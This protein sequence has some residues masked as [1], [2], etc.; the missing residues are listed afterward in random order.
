MRGPIKLIDYELSRP[1]PTHRGLN[2]YVAIQGLVRLHGAPIGYVSVP[3]Q[4]SECPAEAVR[5]AILKEHFYAIAKEQLR[6]TMTVAPRAGH[7]RIDNLFAGFPDDHLDAG[8]NMP[9][10]TVAVCTRDRT[11]HLPLCLDALCRLDYPH[12]DLL[13]V[14]NAPSTEKTEQLVKRSYPNVRYVLEE[15]PGLDWARNCAITKAEGDIIAYTDDDVVVDKYWVQELARVFA[16]D[17]TVMAVTGLVIPYELETEAQI[18]FEQYGG[19]GRGFI[20]KWYQTDDGTKGKAM[21]FGGTGQF[22]TGANMAY[23]R[24]LFEEIGYFDPAL[25]VGTATNGGGD[26]EMFFRVI[27]HGY[28]LVYEPRAIVRHRHRRDYAALKTQIANNGVGLYSYFVCSAGAYP[29]ERIAFL[30]FGLWWMWY[31]NIRRLIKSYLRPHRLPR[32]LIVAELLGGLVGLFR[33]QAAR[34]LSGN[35]LTTRPRTGTETRRVLTGGS[36]AVRTV[37]IA[38]TLEPLSDITNFRAVRIFVN[39]K[40]SPIGSVEISNLGNPV[41]VP[42]LVDAILDTLGDN[43]FEAADCHDKTLKLAE[44]LEAVRGYVCVEPTATLNTDLNPLPPSMSVSVVVATLDRPADLRECLRSLMAQ[45][46]AREVEIVVVDNNPSSGLTAPVLREFPNVRLVEETRQG[47]SY[48]RNAGFFAGK[49]EILIATDD[50]VLAPA[51]WLEKLVAPFIRND[52]MVVTGNILPWELE[53]SS[54]IFFEDYG[55]LGRGFEIRVAD[56]DWFDS[57]GFK[58]VPTW[59]LGATANAA[60]RARIFQDPQI[61]LMLEELGPGTPTGVGEDTYVFYKVIKN[62]YSLYYNPGA[63]VWHK[64]RRN[65]KALRRQLF[66]YSKG[67]VAYH[68]T[69]WLRDGD[70][71]GLRHIFLTLTRIQFTRLIKWCL[72]RNRYPLH[73]IFIEIA[74]NLIGPLALWRSLHRVRRLGR[75]NSRFS[76]EVQRKI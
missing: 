68:I 59:L 18:L 51:D 35:D 66:G 9:L 60:F 28:A 1:I 30:R 42:R 75:S 62:G 4:G 55:G 16:T 5:E 15:R 7:L 45:K 71:R 19:F 33:Y 54:Q 65:M 70:M 63:Y 38:Q 74:G 14:D 69:T 72:G 58:A 56:R 76:V 10:V 32:E 31:W 73:L 12:L 25:D 57:W 26:L 2:G 27:K 40:N 39:R 48:A 23:R 50:D 37:D 20:R 67:H 49:G 61:G 6:H 44:M 64:H 3:V 47:L 22:G 8:K 34:R 13:V 43:L 29:D 52:V 11:E 17:S 53:S 46:T 41:S 21:R 24:K 36:I